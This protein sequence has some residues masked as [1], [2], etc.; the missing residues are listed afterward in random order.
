ML[1]FLSRL[2]DTN[3]RELKKL[4]LMV[5]EINK[6]EDDYKK[7][8]KTDFK[9]K[10]EAGQHVGVDLTTGAKLISEAAAIASKADS[11]RLYAWGKLLLS[12]GE[13]EQSKV[14]LA[15]SKEV[16]STM[17]IYSDRRLATTYSKILRVNVD[18]ERAGFSGSTANTAP[19]RVAWQP[20]QTSLGLASTSR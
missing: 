18:R 12:D 7:L 15:C 5:E 8:K 16:E 17:D 19:S 11:K 9:K 1:K 20:R 2:L 6:L 10:T 3:E 13:S 14:S 4:R